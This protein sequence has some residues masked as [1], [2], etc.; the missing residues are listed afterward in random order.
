MDPRKRSNI[1]LLT[2][3]GLPFGAIAVA[4]SFPGE[5]LRRN[6]YPDRAAC[7]RDYSAQQC[8]Q[9]TGTNITGWHGPYYSANQATRA[10][11]DPGPGRTGAP[12]AIDTSTRGGFG[13]FGRAGHAGS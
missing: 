4:N 10:G 3:L 11:G 7:E 5:E 2:L 12:A 13:N 8:E 6:L 1:V 9:R